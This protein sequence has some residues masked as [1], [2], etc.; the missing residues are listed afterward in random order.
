[1]SSKYEELVADSM[2]QIHTVAANKVE[3]FRKRVHEFTERR[4]LHIGVMA[5][6]YGTS[7]VTLVPIVILLV[8]YALSDE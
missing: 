2:S 6:F 1:M 4:L 5:L 3:Q 7:I 8:A